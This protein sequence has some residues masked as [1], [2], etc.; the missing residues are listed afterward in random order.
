LARAFQHQPVNANGVVL[1]SRYVVAA[2]ESR[3]EFPSAMVEDFAGEPCCSIG[4]H[5]SDHDI[6]Q[7]HRLIL[8]VREHE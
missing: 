3:R 7:R 4:R 1:P 6:G 5:S 8:A 2:D